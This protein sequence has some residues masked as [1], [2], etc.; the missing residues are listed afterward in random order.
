MNC[1]CAKEP[2][3][4]NMHNGNG[5]IIE[6]T[7]AGRETD[8]DEKM[9]EP[10]WLVHFW[11]WRSVVTL[12]SKQNLMAVDL[13]VKKQE[14]WREYILCTQ[15]PPFLTIRREKWLDNEARNLELTTREL[16]AS[17]IKVSVR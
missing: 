1:Y 6:F 4:R 7:W 14:H 15:R 5:A 9:L 3:A 12:G 13:H 10:E 11:A 2:T 17:G 8:N 16:L